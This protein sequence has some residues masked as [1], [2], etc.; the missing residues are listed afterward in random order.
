M[1]PE[2]KNAVSTLEAK[3]SHSIWQSQQR[4]L[5][6]LRDVGAVQAVE[7]LQEI[8]QL[9]ENVKAEARAEAEQLRRT[10]K[11]Q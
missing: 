4:T 9:D 1:S 5:H 2:L 7:E 8:I 11:S 3:A 6:A 10:L